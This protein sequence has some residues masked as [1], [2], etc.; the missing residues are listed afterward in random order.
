MLSSFKLS[1]IGEHRSQEIIFA[2]S[3]HYRNAA[4]IV[5]PGGNINC[6]LQS[7]D[8]IVGGGG[9]VSTGD[10]LWLGESTLTKT[11]LHYDGFWW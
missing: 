9:E 5:V 7:S 10:G 8:D 2:C 3:K 1:W 4:E 6:R 11:D